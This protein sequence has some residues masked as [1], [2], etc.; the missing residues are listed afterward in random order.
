[1]KIPDQTD[2]NIPA[3]LKHDIG[4][5]NTKVRTSQQVGKRDIQYATNENARMHAWGGR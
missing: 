3:K 1:M 4:P 5:F 2:Y